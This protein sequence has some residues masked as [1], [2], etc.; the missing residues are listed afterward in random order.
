MMRLSPVILLSFVILSVRVVLSSPTLYLIGDS[1]IAPHDASE[2]IQGWGVE[3][4]PFFQ[5]IN[6]VNKAASGRSAR[7]YIR[8]GK[9]ADVQS[10]LI[11]GDYVLIQFGHNDGGNPL[12]SDR[13]PVY[14]T[15]DSVTQNVTLS[16][17]TTEIVHTFTYYLYYHLTMQCYTII[18]SQTPDNPYDNS[19]TIA[20]NPPRFVAYA[21]EVAS[22]KD[23]PYVDHFSAVIWIFA[24][25]G[26]TT[27][28]EFYPRD[29]T[30]TNMAG[31]QQVARAFIPA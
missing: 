31:A 25:L 15:N 14:G 21:K 30:H 2:G 13:A 6:I 18:A 1:T 28:D 17:G 26:E 10:S 3:V 4:T 11:S 29:H 24:K 16:D 19:T 12:K 8:E 7:S 27:V 22:L 9:W 23:I 5:G 20:Y